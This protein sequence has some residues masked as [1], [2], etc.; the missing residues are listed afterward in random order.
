M[1]RLWHDLRA[2]W[3]ASVLF[4]LYWLATLAV[5]AMTWQPGGMARGADVLLLTTPLIAGA[6]VGWWRGAMQGG[7]HRSRDRITGGMLAGVLSVELSLMVMKGGVIE[8]VIGGMRGHGFQG[9]EV[10][11]FCILFGV[12]GVLL[13]SAGAALAMILDR[14]RQ[15]GRPAPSA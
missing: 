12:F 6:L 9:G 14:V 13:G 2:H 10:L 7:A 11:E 8:E 5:V 1:R 3:R 15:Q 4:L